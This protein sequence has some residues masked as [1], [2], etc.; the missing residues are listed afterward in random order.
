[1]SQEYPNGLYRTTLPFPE[2]PT[3]VPAQRLIRIVNTAEHEHPVVQTPT[4][5]TDN[6]WTFG[7]QGFLAKD[8]A[9]LKA[10][11]QLPQMGFYVVKETIE[12]GQ[13][14]SL[15]P[16]LLVQLSYTQE[17]KAVIFPGELTQ[18]NQINMK[19]KG[20]LL[21]DLQ[22]DSLELCTFRLLAPSAKAA[23]KA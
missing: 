15:P 22:L 18:G 1:M 11:V 23:P 14:S 4:G 21:G 5:V 3:A 2:Q 17:G 12:L 9:W 20:A 8:A 19:T 10:L 6:V 16:A 13:G 7:T